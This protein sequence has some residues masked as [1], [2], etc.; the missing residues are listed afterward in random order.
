VFYGWYIAVAGTVIVACIG[1][2]TFY[3]FTA[4]VEPI[5]VTFGWS[6]AQISLAMTLRGAETGALNPFIGM[7]ADR[8]PARPLMLTGVVITGLGMLVLS[9][10]TNLAT[11]YISFLIIALGGSLCTSMVPMTT[12]ARWFQR[13]IG[14]ATGI[15]ALGMGIGGFLVPVVTRI[16][17]TYGWRTALIILAVCICSIG[18]PLS[19]VF[20]T[21]PEDYGLV[22]DGKKQATLESSSLSGTDS[23]SMGVKE[24][25]KTRA[26]W[27]IGIVFMLQMGGVTA[28]FLHVM[29]YLATVGIDRT[30]ASLVTM[31]IP[32]VS[33]PARL[34][35]GWLA[36]ILK[37]NHVII[38]SM[39]LISAGLFLFSIINSSSLGLIA[40]FVI[41]LGLGQG[42]ITPLMPPILR[43]YFG[44]K[45]FGTIY[46]LAS[47]FPT[48]G[49]VVAPPLAGWVYDIRGVYDP[50]W[51]VLSAVCILGSVLMLAIPQA[52]NYSN[53]VTGAD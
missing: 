6:Y 28:V 38:I 9:Q 52:S 29:P 43:E 51:L 46:G 48:F 3:G 17:D 23:Y 50:I 5:A 25:L 53:L 12:V 20:R 16:L 14:K 13:N 34:L 44:T 10:V 15:L 2:V 49:V 33:I 30:T 42:G 41:T 18:I 8:W 27:F 26:F 22:P 45:H 7:L 1:G 47:I 32:I 11:F 19:F 31:F 21:R 36:D 40:G 24:A 4:M 35:F 39:V 37:K